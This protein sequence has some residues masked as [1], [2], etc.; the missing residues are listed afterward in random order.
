LR[1]PGAALAAGW[2]RLLA[3]G[4]LDCMQPACSCCYLAASMAAAVL[5]L[6]LL[7]LDV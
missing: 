7:L 4:G 1:A 6:L 5:L 2:L 3:A